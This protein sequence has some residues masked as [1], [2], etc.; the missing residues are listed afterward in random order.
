MWHKLVGML[1]AWWNRMFRPNRTIVVNRRFVRQGKV[2]TS[3]EYHRRCK[4]RK[5]AHRS[6][7]V[8]AHR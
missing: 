7:M 3:R 2:L 8:N 6:R 4:A 5:V 1:V